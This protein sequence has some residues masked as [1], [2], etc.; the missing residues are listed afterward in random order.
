M[1]T[2]GIRAHRVVVAFQRD[3]AFVEGGVAV[4]QRENAIDAGEVDPRGDE[5]VDALQPCQVVSA[6]A[7]GT[8]G[9]ACGRQKA[10]ALVQPQGLFADAGQSAATEI[11]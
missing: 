8:S 1:S 2:R 4:L 5:F 6:V 3:V 11:P 7:A 9:T 10:M